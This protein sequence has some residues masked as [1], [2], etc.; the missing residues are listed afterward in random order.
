MQS[1]WIGQWALI[2]QRTF[3]E[4][5]FTFEGLKVA[6]HWFS[7]FI[8]GK[9]WTIFRFFWGDS[10]VGVMFYQKNH[11]PQKNFLWLKFGNFLWLK[12]WKLGRILESF[13]LL[14]SGKL[15]HLVLKL[16]FNF[17]GSSGFSDHLRDFRDIFWWNLNYGP[18]PIFQTSITQPFSS[19]S[20]LYV[21]LLI[22]YCL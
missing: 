18:F 17:Y 11:Y 5:S 4:S 8:I 19:F 21:M 20:L 14:I 10:W 9:Q 7:A 3:F 1:C 2:D 12:F 22:L 6:W 13:P 15:W 16:N